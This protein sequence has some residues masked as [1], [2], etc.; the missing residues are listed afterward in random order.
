MRG[1]K[2]ILRILFNLIFVIFV[3]K[4]T[5]VIKK[6]KI[7]IDKQKDAHKQVS[8]LNVDTKD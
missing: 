1:F 3:N 2:I 8:K 7:T 4:L 6:L 5:Y